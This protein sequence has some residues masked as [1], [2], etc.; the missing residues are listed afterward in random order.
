[1]DGWMDGPTVAKFVQNAGLSRVS[2]SLSLR[3]CL[4]RVRLWERWGLRRL[5]GERFR[6]GGWAVGARGRWR[7]GGRAG[8][9]SEEAL[10]GPDVKGG[11]SEGWV[12]P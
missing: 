5:E 1:M 4:C 10:Q 9:I 8:P 6:A 11:R 7:E 12:L 2:I 3:R